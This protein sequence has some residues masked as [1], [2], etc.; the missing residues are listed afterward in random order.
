MQLQSLFKKGG[1][2]SLTKKHFLQMT[3]QEALDLLQ[4]GRMTGFECRVRDLIHGKTQLPKYR[5][6]DVRRLR[7]ELGIS[8]EVMGIV[9][10]VRDKTILRWETDGENVPETV[11][12]VLCLLDKCRDSF[13]DLFNPRTKRFELTQIKK[14][15][16]RSTK[17]T[18]QPS[19]GSASDPFDSS[20]IEQRRA[21]M[22][23]TFD[24]KAII[25]LRR[26]MSMSREAFADMLD[27]S[28]STLTK[29][30]NDVVAPKGPSLILLKSLWLHGFNALPE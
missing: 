3:A 1:L 14:A 8:Q 10:G 21:M 2:M 22:P 29:W 7:E 26:R 13:F 11:S 9:C 20:M 4:I 27:I 19:M 28:P 23:E 16:K 6:A 5:P 24:A 15:G 25:H 12:I 30:E 17:K 18:Q